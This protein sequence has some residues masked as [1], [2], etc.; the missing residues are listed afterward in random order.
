HPLPAPKKPKKK[1]VRQITL[2]Y[3]RVVGNASPREIT[4][5]TTTYLSRRP[6]LPYP[7]S[8]PPVLP[9]CPFCDQIPSA[10][11]PFSHPLLSIVGRRRC[12]AQLLAIVCSPI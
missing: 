11:P 3:P 8:P 12:R 2:K 4:S 6:P 7:T 10:P 9:S 5:T 1:P